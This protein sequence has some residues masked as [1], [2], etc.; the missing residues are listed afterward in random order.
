MLNIYT[1]GTYTSGNEYYGGAYIVY[2]EDKRVHQDS[3]IGS[4]AVSMRNV[5]GEL[6][7]VMHATKWVAQNKQKAIIIHDYNGISKWITGEWS[8][9]NEFTQ[10][11]VR[12]MQPYYQ[13]G[14]IRFQWV[15][16]HTGVLGNELVDGLARRAV[17][18]KKQWNL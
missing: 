9:N 11:Y 10:A 8:A 1:D 3:G 2:D 4:K 12:F 7:A 18:D 6:S 17:I 15:K 13:R 5:A 14:I 16:G